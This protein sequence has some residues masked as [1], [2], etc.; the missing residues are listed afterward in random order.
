MAKKKR[1][2][3]PRWQI[4]R[5]NQTFIVYGDEEAAMRA[6]KSLGGDS[7]ESSGY[8]DEESNMIRGARDGDIVLK[9]WWT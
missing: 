7:Y 6:K 8:Y 1:T 3:S 9:D 2:Q 4:K 5:G